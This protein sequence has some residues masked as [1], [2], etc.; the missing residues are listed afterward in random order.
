MGQDGSSP[1]GKHPR[2]EQ[3]SVTSDWVAVLDSGMQYV[4]KP[5]QSITSGARSSYCS[6]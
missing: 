4:E 5:S 6:R 3:T 1:A 2:C